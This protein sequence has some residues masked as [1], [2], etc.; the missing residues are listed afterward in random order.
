MTTLKNARVGQRLRDKDGDEWTR[1][2]GGA[3]CYSDDGGAFHSESAL[4]SYEDC[5]P[6]TLIDT[7]PEPT[8][9]RWEA[10]ATWGTDD[11]T[12]PEGDG[13]EPFAV[14]EGRLWWKRR[15]T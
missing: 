12:P 4:A 13:W 11:V 6:F 1:C 5:G 2:H 7:P 9:A 14:S 15:A 8:P 10:A 3:V